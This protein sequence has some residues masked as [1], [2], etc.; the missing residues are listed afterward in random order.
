M[1]DLFLAPVG[2]RFGPPL[3]IRVL[4]SS[5]GADVLFT[6]TRFPGMPN[7]AWE[8][9]VVAMRKELD[10]LKVRLESNPS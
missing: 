7:D 10:Q 4:H 8:H 5:V 1:V 6:L 9:G 2:A 3:P